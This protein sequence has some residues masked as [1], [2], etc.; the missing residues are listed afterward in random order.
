[1]TDVFGPVPKVIAPTLAHLWKRNILNQNVT[2]VASQ[3]S[4]CVSLSL[5]QVPCETFEH[6]SK[7]KRSSIVDHLRRSEKQIE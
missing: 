7:G 2:A 4:V 5:G 6:D 3:I 1:M